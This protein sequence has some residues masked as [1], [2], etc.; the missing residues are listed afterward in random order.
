M[1]I[2]ISFETSKAM[3]C[4]DAN[5]ALNDD[6]YGNV[7]TLYSLDAFIGALL[8]GDEVIAFTNVGENE[9]FI[10][11]HPEI[12][13]TVVFPKKCDDKLYQVQ[14]AI[15][16][17]L[18]KVP[19]FINFYEN[20]CQED[21]EIILRHFENTDE[22]INTTALITSG[23]IFR[24]INNDASF[25]ANQIESPIVLIHQFQVE[26]TLN[27][28]NFV[29]E[30]IRKA[31]TENIHKASQVCATYF[32]A[33]IPFFLNFI[34][35]ECKT[36]DEI[37]KIT[38]EYRNSSNLKNFRNWLNDLNVETD[39]KSVLKELNNIENITKDIFKQKNIFESFALGFPP[40]ISLPSIAEIEGVITGHKRHFRFYRRLLKDALKNAK[41]ENELQR[42]FK[43][44]K[45][46]ALNL[47]C[48]MSN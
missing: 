9:P 29:R 40:S 18:K 12:P 3:E 39:L 38:M 4:F 24:A 27:S 21:K 43:I 8:L 48:K 35:R 41:F 26:N 42:V 6:L 23:D 22:Y 15:A 13:V 47:V 46:T 25:F 10:I 7:L 36:I 33:N 31:W 37:W 34:L 17:E 1:K 20:K 44:D 45:T 2:S 28:P 30:T 5:F 16:A 11:N 14:L 32:T 19:E